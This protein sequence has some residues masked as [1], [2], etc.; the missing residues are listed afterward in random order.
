MLEYE[1]TLPPPKIARDVE[2]AIQK[3]GNIGLFQIWAFVII[4]MGMVSGAFFL[5]SLQYF[6]KMPTYFECKMTS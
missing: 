3:A 6:E 5:Y 1:L 2:E 4:V